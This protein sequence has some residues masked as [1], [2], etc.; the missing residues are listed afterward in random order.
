MLSFLFLISILPNAYANDSERVDKISNLCGV[1]GKGSAIDKESYVKIGGIEQ[2]VTIKGDSCDNPVVLFIHGGPGNTLSPYSENLYGKWKSEFTLVQWDQRGS[3]K[4]FEANQEQGL[5]IEKMSRIKL[6]L[7]LMIQ[8][9][10]ELTHYLQKTLSKEKIIITGGS[11]GSVLAAK[12]ITAQP[13]SYHFYVGFSQLVN[14]ERNLS[15][16]YDAVL[17]K[18]KNFDDLEVIKILTALGR[19]PWEDVK[20]FG[21]LRRVIRK[22][23]SL[24]SD[25][26]LEWLIASEYTSTKSRAAY[27]AG[28]ELSFMKFIGFKSRGMSMDIS[29]DMDNTNFE[30]PIYLIQGDE[31]LLTLPAVT[32]EYFNKINAPFKKLILVNRAGHDPNQLIIEAQLEALKSGIKK[33][34]F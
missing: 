32:E 11:W 27:Y 17:D 12:M 20:S 8:D 28:E 23:E 31:D 24:A 16:S 33:P 22:Y 26:G 6:N 4:T 25:G 5:T 21:Q 19:P 1:D 3:G 30:V 9:G 14:Y 7:N 18:A 34:G 29:L 15:K 13:E 2:W 10:L